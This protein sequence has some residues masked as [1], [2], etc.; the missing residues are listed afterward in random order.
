MRLTALCILGL[1][2]VLTACVNTHP[3]RITDYPVNTEA[4]N[5]TTNESCEILA[6]EELDINPIDESD[7]R[8][9][10]NVTGYVSALETANRD[11]LKKLT[12]A[13]EQYR[14]CKQE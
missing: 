5:S 12:K 8:K 9:E 14:T 4:S 7:F 11:Y 10:R 1:C 13:Q 3:K 2:F 6:L